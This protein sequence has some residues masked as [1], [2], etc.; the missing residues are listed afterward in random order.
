MHSN[1]FRNVSIRGRMA[2]G[3]ICFENALKHF[4]YDVEDWQMILRELWSF[5][6]IEYIDEWLYS[7]AE[8]KASSILEDL[9]FS[10]KG[11][12]KL[13]RSEYGILKKLYFNSDNLIQEL[14]DL[15]F[16]LGTVEMYGQIVDNSP[17]TLEELQKIMNVMATNGI[18]LP[19]GSLFLKFSF[20][21]DGW[22]K[23]F[24]REEVFE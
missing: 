18:Q 15:L 3:I 10:E 1:E 20:T 11:F 5:T 22:G 4:D 17:K 2:F 19:Q 14:T 23:G 6:E 7:F 12:E 21:E 13:T 16:W 9:S 24:T 8:Y